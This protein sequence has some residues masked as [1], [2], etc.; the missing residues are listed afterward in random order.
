METNSV[1]RWLLQI[2]LTSVVV[3]VVVVT[4]MKGQDAKV[5]ASDVLVDMLTQ[6]S[7][8]SPRP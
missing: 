2:H 8:V 7:H 1:C 4:V 3:M 5:I 6:M